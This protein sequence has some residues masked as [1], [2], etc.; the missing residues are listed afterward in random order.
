MEDASIAEAVYIHHGLF[1]AHLM[2]SIVGILISLFLNSVE[3]LRRLST[4]KKEKDMK[5]KK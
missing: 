4:I 1:Y 3:H 2:I 5:E